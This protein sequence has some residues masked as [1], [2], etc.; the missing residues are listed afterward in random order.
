MDG[1]WFECPPGGVQPIMCGAR[2]WIAMHGGVCMSY[3]VYFWLRAILA[4]V[5]LLYGGCTIYRSAATPT[6]MHI[7]EIVFWGLGPP[8]WF[9]A[10]YFWLDHGWVSLPPG[11]AKDEFLKSVKDYGD[12][13]S[14]IWAAVLAAVLFLYKK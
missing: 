13:A 14:K 7:W 12:F 1:H 2:K 3:K 4:A 11:A 10:E 5:L 8:V 6:G 9:F